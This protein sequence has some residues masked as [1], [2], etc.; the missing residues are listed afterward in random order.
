MN[1]RALKVIGALTIA[2]AF[3]SLAGH[4]R[5]VAAETRWVRSIK[6]ASGDV[7]TGDVTLNAVTVEINGTIDGNLHARTGYLNQVGEVTGDMTVTAGRAELRGAVGGDVRVSGG[8]LS[9]YG[10]I[11][12]DVELTGG[13]LTLVEGAV[14]SGNVTVHGG[15]LIVYAAARIEGDLRG[16]VVNAT[17]EGEIGRT[18]DLRV[19]QLTLAPGS[20]IGGELQ[21]ESRNIAR[22]DRGAVVVGPIERLEPGAGFR[23]GRILFWHNA[24][25]VRFLLVLVSGGL[26]LLIRPRWL[27]EVADVPRRAP[28]TTLVSGVG[29]AALTPLLLLLLAMLVITLPFAFIGGLIYLA[30]AYFSMAITGVALGRVVTRR[31]VGDHRRL[32]NLGALVVGCGLLAAIRLLPVPWF[33]L[34]FTALITIVGFGA[35]ASRRWIAQEERDSDRRAPRPVLS[36]VLGAIIVGGATALALIAIGTAMIGFVAAIATASRSAAFLW[37]ITPAHFGVSALV[38]AAMAMLLV[39]IGVVLMLVA[40]A[41]EREP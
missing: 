22:I 3:A 9:L 17:I 41:S 39:L 11:A 16:Q 14:V 29:V 32:V 12:G 25:V 36:A 18:V 10:D 21:Y 15:T 30:T 40:R 13:Q 37:T 8:S 38:L 33:G 28:L 2:V 27:V 23:W 1:L 31:L 26:L 19:R 20:T 7:I 5:P 6:I 35:V 34:A 24:F 4:D